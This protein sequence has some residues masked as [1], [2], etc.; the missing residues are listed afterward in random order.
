MSGTVRMVRT[1][2]RRASG[3]RSCTFPPTLV[4]AA[5]SRS[6]WPLLRICR[7]ATVVPGV[8]G[9]GTYAAATWIGDLAPAAAHPVTT[10]AASTAAA[11]IRRARL[12]PR[13][14][15]GYRSRIRSS[16]AV[17]GG[18]EQADRRGSEVEHGRVE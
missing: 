14:T 16:A 1:P 2:A 9:A 10:S 3:A 12:N 13:T 5:I 11:A 8:A 17:N 4:C 15:T 7:Y 18:A 6:A